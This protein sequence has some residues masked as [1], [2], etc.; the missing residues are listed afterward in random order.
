MAIRTGGVEVYP[1]IVPNLA[2]ET[3]RSDLIKSNIEPLDDMLGGGLEGGTTTLIVGQAATGKSTLA[4]IYSHAALERAR[5]SPCSSSR[6]GWRR[7]SDA[8]RALE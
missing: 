1:R 4:S 6:S 5:A 2:P 8:R 3:D 7:S